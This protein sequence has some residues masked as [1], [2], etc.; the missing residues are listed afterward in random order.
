MLPLFDAPRGRWRVQYRSF[1][2]APSNV[3]QLLLIVVDFSVVKILPLGAVAAAALA[4]GLS[5][6]ECFALLQREQSEE[7][8][9]Y[10]LFQLVDV[11]W[12]RF[13]VLLDGHGDA[14]G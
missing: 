7:L 14:I 13:V 12:L 10:R 1:I 11:Q 5:G 8:Q 9:K 6:G 3:R 4:L 2:A